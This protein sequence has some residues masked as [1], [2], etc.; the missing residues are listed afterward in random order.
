MKYMTRIREK[1][2]DI[3]QDYGN[4]ISEGLGDLL[5]TPINQRSVGAVASGIILAVFGGTG[6]G[7]G[8]SSPTRWGRSYD[9][10]SRQSSPSRY[11]GVYDTSRSA[12]RYFSVAQFADPTMRTIAGLYAGTVTAETTTGDGTRKVTMEGYF[13]Q[14]REPEVWE[15]ACAQADT[16]G[17]GNVTREE[18]KR[19]HRKIIRALPEGTHSGPVFR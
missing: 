7:C 13:S 17:D 16:D 1:V 11:G 19:L 4:R 2:N 3:A 12:K 18:A 9:S 8:Q 14:I 6:G 5:T 15:Q 10:S